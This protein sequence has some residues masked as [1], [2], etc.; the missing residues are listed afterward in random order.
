[1]VDTDRIT[2]AAKEL[3]GKVQGA[4]GDLTGSRKDSVEGRARE[5]QGSAENLYGQVKDSVR[6]AADRVS[7]TARDVGGRVRDAFDDTVGSHGIEDRASRA[8]GAT[9]AQYRRAERSLRHGA[10][11]AYGYAEDAYE[12][13]SRALRQGGREV[14]HQVADHPIA[15]MLVAGLLGYG[16]GLLIHG[17]D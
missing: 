16:L 17:R 11:A 4:A 9:E 14:T 7:E 2:G 1:M 6:D 8:R 15:A 3:G 5:V 12:S 13:G 10:D